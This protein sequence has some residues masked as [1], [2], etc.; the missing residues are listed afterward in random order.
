METVKSGEGMDLYFIGKTLDSS[1]RA[2]TMSVSFTTV[3]PTPGTDL[4]M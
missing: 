3:F 1:V 4:G 2:V